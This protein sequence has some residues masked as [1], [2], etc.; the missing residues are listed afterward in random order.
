MFSV[1]YIAAMFES[2]AWGTW[3]PTGGGSMGNHEHGPEKS[4]ISIVKVGFSCIY[5]LTSCKLTYFSPIRGY[6]P[7]SVGFSDILCTCVPAE[8]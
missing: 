5:L 7:P 2:W 3:G 4:T 1:V 6:Y 8:R